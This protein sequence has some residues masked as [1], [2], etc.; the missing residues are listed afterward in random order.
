MKHSFTVIASFI[1]LV[2][3]VAY[4][5]ASAAGTVTVRAESHAKR[6]LFNGGSEEE[7]IEDLTLEREGY[8]MIPLPESVAEK[9][10]SIINDPFE[11]RIFIHIKG[12]DEDFYRTNFFSG[13]M[14]GIEDVRYGYADGVS[15]VE[16][17]TGD[18]RVPVIEYTPGSFFVKVVPPRDIYERIIVVDSGHGVNDPG[19]V[20]YGIEERSITT[21]VAGRL[22]TLLQDGKTMV[23]LSAPDETIKSEKERSEMINSLE[24]D[25][26]I[27]I[28][29]GADPD[30]RVTNGVEIASSSD[31]AEKAEELSA[32]ISSACDQ[33]NLGSSVRSFPGLTEYLKVPY[34]RIKLGIITNRYEA[35][36]MNSEDYQEKVSRTIAAFINGTGSFAAGSAIS[37]G[38]GF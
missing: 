28:H 15:T 21:A 37:A 31:Q 1:L 2:L 16:L 22:C 13:D 35:E 17:I 27:S 11:N 19:S 23:C 30:T 14:T 24:P 36:K 25:L 33:K 4:F 8:L 29:T 9:D 5:V 3:S 18:V 32:L 6:G 20:V 10:V 26:L 12:A 34:L 38:G 7:T